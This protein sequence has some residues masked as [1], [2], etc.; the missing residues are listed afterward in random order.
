[1]FSFFSAPHSFF[2][3]LSSNREGKKSK[4]L[5]HRNRWERERERSPLQK[6]MEI[7]HSLPLVHLLTTKCMQTWLGQTGFCLCFFFFFIIFLFWFTLLL[8][9]V[10][11]EL[12]CVL[13]I[14]LCLKSFERQK[15][16]RETE[17]ERERI[18]FYWAGNFF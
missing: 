1:M 6:P 10:L 7:I 12:D 8:Q 13:I 5:P 2:V 15:R 11:W 17:G 16:E 3:S 9:F 14:C 4:K 18:I